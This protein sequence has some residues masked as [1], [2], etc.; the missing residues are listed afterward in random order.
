MSRARNKAANTQDLGRSSRGNASPVQGGG[1]PES[2]TPALLSLA[3]ACLVVVAGLAA[4]CHSFDGAFLFD[5]RMHI[6]QKERIRSLSPFWDLITR[7]RR[8]VVQLSLALNYAFGGLRV[9]GYHAVNLTIHLLAGLTLFGIIR[10]TLS[11]PRL[12]K[13]HGRAAPWLAFAVALLWVVHPLNTQSVT[14]IIQRG[15][16]FMGLFYLLTLYCLIRGVASGSRRVRGIWFVAA[17]LA[18]GL[19]MGSK[20]VAVTI[21]VVVLLYDRT[22]LS[23][24]FVQ[25]IDRRWV[26]YLGLAATWIVLVLCGVVGGVLNPSPGGSATVGFGYKDVKPWWYAFSQPG[27]ILHY[28]RLSFWP[29]PLCLDYDWPVV[30]TASAFVPQSFAILALLGGTAWGLVRRSW[31][32]FAGAWFFLIL[33]PT[34]SFIPI[35]DLAFEHRMYLSLAAVIAVVVAGVYMAIRRLAGADAARM[36]SLSLAGGGLLAVTALLLGY[37][38]DRRNRDYRDEIDMWLSIVKVRPDNVRAHYNLGNCFERQNRDIEAIEHFEQVLRLKPDHADARVNMAKSLFKVDRLNESIAAFREALAI[39]PRHGL[40]HYN[41]AIALTRKGEI[42]KAIQHYRAALEVD[43][44]LTEAHYNLAKLLGE[45][46]QFEES[47]QQFKLALEANPDHAESHADLAAAYLRAGRLDEATEH[48][49]AVLRLEPKGVKPAVIA[50]AHYNL[51]NILFQKK[52]YEQAVKEFRAA[53]RIDARQPHVFFALGWTYD[54]MGR[55]AKAIEAYRQTLLLDPNYGRARKRLETLEARQPPQE[56][57][58]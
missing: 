29:H 17:V 41:L 51:G 1:W 57:Q 32:G 53:V 39:R 15:E 31:W 49:R 52:E 44:G 26:L 58:K 16:S 46:G 45:A 30:K 22:F 27:V 3:L 34:S 48:C 8:P 6:L 13:A 23:K 28:L 20:A 36:R 33:A 4:Y 12:A 42:A 9:W 47:V 21:P 2:Q 7:T 5:D 14:Y 35:K 10:R 43:P 56:P 19:S 40:A 37:T 11:S 25:A 18:C 50:I 38:T 55:T 24:S 54:Q